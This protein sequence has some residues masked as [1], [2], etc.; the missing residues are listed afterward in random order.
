MNLHASAVPQTASPELETTVATDAATARRANEILAQ[1]RHTI[2]AH[3]DR[4]FAVLL[5]LQYFAGIAAA[6]FISPLTWSGTRTSVHFHV[7]AAI[8][9]GG[10]IVSLPIAAAVNSPGKT[11][12]RYLIAIGQM[13]MSALLIHL[14]GGRIETHFHV[15]GSLAF[16]AL[17]RDWRVLLV[18]SA[19]TAVD[20]LIRGIYWPHSVFAIT[21]VDYFRWLEHAG[22]VVFEVF[23]LSLACRYNLREM[24]QDALQKAQLERSHEAIEEQV[25]RRTVELLVAKE[26]IELA[27]NGSNDGMWDCNLDSNE[28]YFSKRFNQLLGYAGDEK[29]QLAPHFGSLVSHLHP[30]DAPNVLAALERH[31]SQGGAF[32]VICQM[33]LKPSG[34]R[35]CRLRG[36]AVHLPNERFRRMAGFL[37]DVSKL[38]Q[39]EE[40][41][42][43]AAK[44]D[45]LTDLPNRSLIMELVHRSLESAKQSNG[46]FAVMFLDFDRFKIINDSLGHDVGDALLCEIAERLR[47]SLGYTPSI[48]RESCGSVAGR[49]GGDEFVVLL[50]S[51]EN[52]DQA[53]EIAEQLLETFARPYQLG[54]NQVFSSASIGIVVGNAT[55]ERA[56]D[57]LRDADTAMYEAKRLGKA[58]YVVF[59]EPMR[60]RVQRRH[61]LENELRRAIPENQCSLVYQPIVSLESGEI[62]S[63]EA[64]LRWQHPTEGKVSPAEFIPIAEESRMILQIGEWVL[65]EGAR[66]MAEWI[67]TLGPAAPPTISLNLSRKQFACSDLPAQIQRIAEEVGLPPH[68]LQLEV[69]EDAFASDVGSAIAAMKAIKRLGVRLAIDDFGT[70]CSSFASLHEFPAD[71]L[72]ID[73]MLLEG[74]EDSKD[75]AALVH[76]LAV[77]VRNLGMEMVA[78]GIERETQV[79]VLRELGCQCGQGYLFARP[80]TA[81]AFEELAIASQASCPVIAGAAAF[82]SRWTELSRG[83]EIGRSVAA[84]NL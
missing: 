27:V 58:R 5:I 18:A 21:S 25:A 53:I 70:G 24:Q 60:M 39:V 69:T 28:C 3:V 59:D 64:L 8:V 82:G 48:G 16:L 30:D 7:W 36:Q 11:R 77:L 9:L 74:I 65:R 10:L 61:L 26:Q 6:V 15:F 40:E 81:A 29:E 14:S 13:L 80:I 38:K 56:E 46:Q 45:R 42:A 72:K 57:I 78:E 62:C 17:Y 52:V 34:W 73:R 12:T 4:M 71:V 33:K 51:V 23:F 66:Q 19:V 47:T 20:H 54:P 67:E 63:V 35:W 79:V 84:S 1:R 43:R 37:S 68:R 32:D 49:M 22:W 31:L 2:Y 41:L 55:Y 76:S 50:D 83:A 75:T 44:F